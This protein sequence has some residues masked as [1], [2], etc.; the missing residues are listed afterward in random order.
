MIHIS[1]AAAAELKRRLNLRTTP[2][3]CIRIGVEGGGCAAFFYTLDTE[4]QP[5]ADD[6]K[7]ECGSFQV[8]TASRHS[9]YLSGLS[10]DYSEDLVGGSFRF[11]NPNAAQTCG[12]GTS[13]TLDPDDAISAD[14]THPIEAPG[15]REVDAVRNK[16]VM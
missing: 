13:F 5:S 3:E 6:I 14:C 16:M 1:A 11:V 8:V 10:I 4:S 2:H 12:C 9:P 7:I 15:G